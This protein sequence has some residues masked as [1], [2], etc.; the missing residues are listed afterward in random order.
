MLA[1]R[2]PFEGE[3]PLSV[4]IQHLNNEPKRLDERRPDLDPSLARIVHTLLAKKPEARYQS[5]ADLLVDLRGLQIEGLE[6]G[7]PTDVEQWTTSDL[8]TT[9][10][11][12][13]AATQQLQSVMVAEAQRQRTRRPWWFLIAVPATLVSGIAFAWLIRP[14]SLLDIA[15]DQQPSIQHKSTV[16]KQFDYAKELW[17][18]PAF[19]SVSQHFPPGPARQH[20]PAHHRPDPRSPLLPR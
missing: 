12:K 18:V 4:A 14:A 6:E 3:T 15:P 8:R 17:T 10:D 1:G 2:P 20:G 11:Q 7:W 13:S 19:L 16:D 9:L 5:A